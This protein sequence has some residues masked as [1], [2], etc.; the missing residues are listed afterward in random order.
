MNKGILYTLGSYILWGFLPIYMKTLS[1]VSPLEIL[2]HRIVWSFILLA[3]A[4]TVGN[5]W[6][7]LRAVVQQPRTL[8]T[9]VATAT[10]LSINWLTYIWAVQ[11]GHIIETSLGYFM[12]PLV[13]VLLGVLLLH[14]RLRQWQIIGIG[15]ATLGV[16]YLTITAGTPPWIS[17]ILAFS[18][19][20]YGLLRK[21]A[22]LESLEG[23]SLET[24][25]LAIPA[26][27]YLL[28]LQAS[29]SLLF[30]HS[31]ASTTFLL[32]ATG[33]ITAVPLL[34]F[35]AG[36]RLLSMTTLGILQY[37]APTIQ[38]V[39]GIYLYGETMTPTRLITFSLIW[40]AL[41]VFSLERLHE[42]QRKG[43]LPYTAQ[44]ARS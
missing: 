22:P 20:G 17:L 42:R 35:A 23:L 34:L 16:L 36:A 37:F 13:S 4:L 28:Y 25:V 3:A 43:A 11:H 12:N 14:E 2:S 29:G 15:I 39:I 38:L 41:L 44:P 27:V 1:H 8:C 32:I 40:L 7:W 9:F 19:G 30:L 21:I 18:F 5:H 31:T 33:V 26:L 6:G 10:L 24:M